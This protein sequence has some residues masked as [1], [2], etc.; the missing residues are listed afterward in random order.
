M[1]IFYKGAPIRT[2]W[3]I[4]DPRSIGLSARAPHIP[5]DTPRLMQHVARGTTLS[6]YISLTVSY[7]I[8]WDYAMTRGRIRPTRR[9][10]AYVYE[11]SLDPMPRGVT[12][13]EPLIEIADT[14]RHLIAAMPYRHD[15]SQKFLIGVT[16]DQ[17]L[18]PLSRQLLSRP[19]RQPPPATG[20]PRPPNLSIELETLVRALRDTEVCVLGTIP[21]TC[22]INRI[23]VYP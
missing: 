10:P 13:Y 11:I 12:V 6:P 23:D 14:Y 20:T 4:N 3:H 21:T 15:G 22:V 9:N 16:C 17:V 19:Y 5:A 18:H 1:I 2:H 7:N 8:A